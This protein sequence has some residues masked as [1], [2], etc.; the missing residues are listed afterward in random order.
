LANILAH[1]LDVQ[2][3]ELGDGVFVLRYSDDVLLL[4]KCRKA[5][6]SAVRILL[7]WAR[8]RGIQVK[9]E[10]PGLVKP[11]V[12]SPDMS[13]GR[14]VFD[15]RSRV[16][17]F[18]GAEIAEKGRITLP[19]DKL[20]RKV[21]EL[22]DVERRIVTGTIVGVSLYGDG[23]GIDVYDHE[24][25]GA[26]RDGARSYWI[27]LGGKGEADKIDQALEKTFR[28]SLDLRT[29]PG[30]TVWCARLWGGQ[31][32][33]GPRRAVSPSGAGSPAVQEDPSIVESAGP[34]PLTGQREGSR[35]AEGAIGGSE[36]LHDA[37]GQ[38]PIALATEGETSPA[39]TVAQEVVHTMAD[40]RHAHST[41][42]LGAKGDGRSVNTL[43]INAGEILAELE[44]EFSS[45]D[46]AEG[47]MSG[48]AHSSYDGDDLDGVESVGSTLFSESCRFQQP[49][50][51]ST[52]GGSPQGEEDQADAPSAE[53]SCAGDVANGYWFVDAVGL[54]GGRSVVGAVFVTPNGKHGPVRTQ[55]VSG[56]ADVAI[57]REVTQLVRTREEGQLTVGLAEAALPKAL[58]QPWRRFH[59]P[60]YFVRV[61]ELH[62][63][64]RGLV[65][66]VRVAGPLAAPVALKFELAKAAEDERR[67]AAGSGGSPEQ[68]DSRTRVAG[69]TAS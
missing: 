47:W 56:R 57:L 6:A 24:D 48:N 60:L 62:E 55:I 2:L 29:E 54:C 33:A 25:F 10:R 4:G 35:S 39:G 36:A 64:A 1:S 34:M 32:D 21:A 20:A 40:D 28:S 58:L 3:I 15:V 9:D 65:G 14:L 19:A 51:S 31:A 69:A 49:E 53:P 30:G 67:R 23:K 17:P 43:S 8:E 63:T 5:V 12:I 41:K 52:A 42:A 59:A 61:C 44:G 46:P 68:G 26:K 11:G 27:D 37:T 18:L 22:V 66:A 50:L 38:R 45:E 13:A 16:I 7:A